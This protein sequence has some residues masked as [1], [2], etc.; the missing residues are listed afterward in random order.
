MHWGARGGLGGLGTRPLGAR[1]SCGLE[2][3]PQPCDSEG[4]RVRMRGARA[5]VTHAHPACSPNSYNQ[6]RFMYL[7]TPSRFIVCFRPDRFV[8]MKI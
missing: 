8:S 5:C 7:G 6:V 3:E 4:V 2:V 1:T